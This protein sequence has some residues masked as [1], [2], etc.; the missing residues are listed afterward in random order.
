MSNP[1][2]TFSIIFHR[3]IERIQGDKMP[4][5]VRITINGSY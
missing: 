5:Y 3:R 2:D 4:V 1:S